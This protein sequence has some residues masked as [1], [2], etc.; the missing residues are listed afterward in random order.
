MDHYVKKYPHLKFEWYSSNTAEYFDYKNTF[1]KNTFDYAVITIEVRNGSIV[2]S[3]LGIYNN[4]IFNRE[5]KYPIHLNKL[6][7][8]YNINNILE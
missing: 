2:N 7:R 4:N 5:Y 1:Y 6:R 8:E 3:I